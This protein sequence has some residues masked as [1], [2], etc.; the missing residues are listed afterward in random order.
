MTLID[1]FTGKVVMDGQKIKLD[2]DRCSFD[3]NDEDD[4]SP[5]ADCLEVAKKAWDWLLN[6]I[7][8]D[9]FKREIKDRLIMII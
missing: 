9:K 1:I 4:F 7:G 6:P 5:D 8:I 3:F 2:A